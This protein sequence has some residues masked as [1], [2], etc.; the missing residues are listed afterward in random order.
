MDGRSDSTN[1]DYEDII[2]GGMPCS[3][4]RA[5]MRL[6]AKPSAFLRVGEGMIKPGRGILIGGSL[7]GTGSF[8]T[9][10]FGG[11]SRLILSAD[12]IVAEITLSSNK[13][14]VEVGT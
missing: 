6:D 14:L 8:G 11:R 7:M 3:C 2:V 5:M 13:V 4:R 1:N 12:D 9:S 10:P